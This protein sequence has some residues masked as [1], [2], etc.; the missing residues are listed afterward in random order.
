[1][2]VKSNPI[3]EE[4]IISELVE[5]DETLQQQHLLFLAEMKFNQELIEKRKGRAL[6]QKD[7][8]ERSGL[9]QRDV[10][11]LEKGK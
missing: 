10:S 2:L 5:S 6:T 11:R 8:S 9:S 1:M 4:K 7:I 3:G